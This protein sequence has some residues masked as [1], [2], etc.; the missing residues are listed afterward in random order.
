MTTKTNVEEEQRF[1]KIV[2]QYPARAVVQEL[3]TAW[4]DLKRQMVECT[5][6]GQLA[7]AP[8]LVKAWMER[9]ERLAL[10]WLADGVATPLNQD[11]LEVSRIEGQPEL[12]ELEGHSGQVA[13]REDFVKWARS[14][15]WFLAAVDTVVTGQV[16]LYRYLLPSGFVQVVRVRYFPATQQAVVFVT[17]HDSEAP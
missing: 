14:Q 7:L 11:E 10:E 15:G 2:G 6:V 13:S 4:F 5:N 12:I 9:S 8:G 1:S 17:T 3:T 16:W